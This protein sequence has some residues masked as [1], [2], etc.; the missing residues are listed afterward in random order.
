M[1]ADTKAFI[2]V[3]RFGLGARLG[4]LKRA[5][6]DPHGWL[7]AQLAAPVT[8]SEFDGLASAAANARAFFE[9]DS[10][11]V[12]EVTKLFRERFRAIYIAE[13]AARTRAMVKSAVPFRERLVAFWS[14]HFTVSVKRPLIAGLAGAFEREAIRP[15]V[16]GSFADMLL[17]VTRHPAMLLYLDN[18]LS[19]G[20]TSTVGQRARK[21]L[22]E[23]LAREILELHTLGVNGGYG[24]AD[25][26][27]LA[28]L[29]TGWSLSRREPG[30]DP[31]TFRFYAPAHEPGPK[32][33][34][35]VRYEQGG[36]SEGE[37]A[38]RALARHPS[39]ATFIATKFARHFIADDPPAAAVARLAQV[40][41]DTGGDL[42]A[43]AAAL[44]DLPAA[45]AD[46][47]AKFKT[48]QD[49]VLAALRATDI[50][51]NE[52]R[53]VV[54]IFDELGQT[55]FMALSPAGWDDT[56]SGW[57]GPEAVLRRA[58]WSLAFARRLAPIHRPLA[59][60]EETIA[61]VVSAKTREAV[62]RAPSAEQG[63]ALLFAS[64]EFQRR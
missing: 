44:V 27:E 6:G 3:N 18:V 5:A 36:E 41:R 25:V 29:I 54:A 35:G 51:P 15:H 24:Q 30:A 31:G 45:W 37:A 1:A 50:V 53:A 20:P 64:P 46:P 7:K 9:A 62:Q 32:T 28:K 63:L 33:L 57:A 58:E 56:A 10:K 40:F 16:T 55:P 52:P 34:L 49:F 47:L 12:N 19:I 38:L 23:N 39:T 11:N 14:N 48:P 60:L 17:A 2:A 61:P 13:V 26:I 8:L 21:G 43:L 59:L 4:E 22:N 42:K